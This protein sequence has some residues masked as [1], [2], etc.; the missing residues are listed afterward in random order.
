MVK[1]LI[2]LVNVMVSFFT[3]TRV[4]VRISHLVWF[5]YR[6]AYSVYRFYFDSWETKKLSGV[7]CKDTFF[8]TPPQMLISNFVSLALGL[9]IFVIA[10]SNLHQ[11]LQKITNFNFACIHFFRKKKYTAIQLSRLVNNGKSET[12]WA[13][14]L[15]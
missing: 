6:W 3:T 7:V 14:S 12:L 15:I 13:F 1:G 10:H 4:T 9:F 8:T 5:N 2:D 11:T